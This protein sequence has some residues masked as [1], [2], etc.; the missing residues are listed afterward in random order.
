MQIVLYVLF[1][2][3]FESVI[4]DLSHTR[5]IPFFPLL[6]PFISGMLEILP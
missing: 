5:G 6:I 3:L 4:G 2:L 1:I